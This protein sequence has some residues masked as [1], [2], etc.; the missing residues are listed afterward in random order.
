MAEWNLAADERASLQG[1]LAEELPTGE[2]IRIDAVPDQQRKL[3]LSTDGRSFILQ[4]ARARP[5]PITRTIADE[6]AILSVLAGSPVPIPA[7]VTYCSDDSIVGVPFYVMEYVPGDVIPAGHDLPARFGTPRW[8]ARLCARLV[9]TMADLHCVDPSGCGLDPQSLGVRLSAYETML[10]DATSVTGRALPDVR[11]TVDWLRARRPSRQPA[12]CLV[13]GDL[14]PH[15]VVFTAATDPTVAGL[16]DWEFAAYTNPL[17]DLGFLLSSWYEADEA[18]PIADLEA[19]YHDHPHVDALVR[20]RDRGMWPFTRADGSWSRRHLVDA[21]AER[22]GGEIDDAQY[23][24]VFGAFMAA[25][26]WETWHRRRLEG[27]EPASQWEVIVRY[28]E[29]VCR[30]LIDGNLPL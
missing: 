17:T 27:G 21:Y 26:L 5:T 14:L 22:T 15:N 19:E 7:P 28:Q 30:E 3:R 1:Y 13:H 25:V 16:I 20:H 18:I 11:R 24:R 23:Y 29:R 8:R 4:G 2:P 10:D 9:E 12:P 6:Y